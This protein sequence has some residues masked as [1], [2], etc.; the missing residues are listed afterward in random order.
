[1]NLALFNDIAETRS[2]YDSAPRSAAKKLIE[3]RWQKTVIAARSI[4]KKSPRRIEI[5]N[6]I[7]ELHREP[8]TA[9]LSM[10]EIR[11]WPNIHDRDKGFGLYMKKLRQE[12]EDARE[13]KEEAKK[14]QP[15]ESHHDASYKVEFPSWITNH[16]S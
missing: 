16:G 7:R 5:A 8:W 2:K 1:M 9:W 3:K 4:A 11:N 6:K 15:R 13:E 14:S 12:L 10:P